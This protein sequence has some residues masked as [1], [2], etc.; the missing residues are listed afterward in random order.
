MR[1][2]AMSVMCAS[3]LGMAATAF[4]GAYAEQGRAEEMP[5]AVEMAESAPEPELSDVFWYV[6]I[7]TSFGIPNFKADNYDTGWGY[8]LRGGLRL[9]DAFAVEVEAE[10][11]ASDYENRTGGDAETWAVTLG[12]KL[13]PIGGNFQP[14]ALVA[15]GYGGAERP[16][17]HN[18]GF[19]ARFGMGMD[20]L[21]TDSIGIVAELDYLLGAGSMS[22][23][24]QI[25]FSLGVIYNFL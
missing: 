7:G 25:P 12:A 10:H 2:A 14:F 19:V 1:K 22:D 16:S 20:M 5:E 6:Q 15:A 17:D 11:M 4:A 18:D 24:H 3:M 13:F 21:I 8:N 23:W 9:T